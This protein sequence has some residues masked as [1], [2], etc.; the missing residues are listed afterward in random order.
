MKKQII[1]SVAA[2]AIIVIACLG[3]IMTSRNSGDLVNANIEALSRGEG[4]LFGP[5]CSKSGTSGNYYMKLCSQCKG[6][7]GHYAMDVV[8]FCPAN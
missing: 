8:A 7:F 2:F 4:G 3:V 6:S 1:I 5:M